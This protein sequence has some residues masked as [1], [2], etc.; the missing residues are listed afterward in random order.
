MKP[1]LKRV[2]SADVR[3]ANELIARKVTV[4]VDL[5]PAAARLLRQSRFS[6]EEINRAFA[7]ARRIVSGG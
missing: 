5:S 6:R 4:P 2:A 1:V 3:P 7:E